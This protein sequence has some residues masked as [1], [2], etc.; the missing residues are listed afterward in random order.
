MGIEAKENVPVRTTEAEGPYDKIVPNTVVSEVSTLLNWDQGRPIV[1]AAFESIPVRQRSLTEQLFPKIAEGINNLPQI[2]D[3]VGDNSLRLAMKSLVPSLSYIPTEQDKSNLWKQIEDDFDGNKPPERHSFQWT[4]E[5]FEGVSGRL[6]DNGI[7]PREYFSEMG[8]DPKAQL[9]VVDAMREAASSVVCSYAF[10]ITRNVKD[11]QVLVDEKT[12]QLAWDALT[13]LKSIHDQIVARIKI[14][15]KIKGSFKKNIPVKAINGKIPPKAALALVIPL[16]LLTSCGSKVVGGVAAP[17]R[18]DKNEALTCKILPDRLKIDVLEGCNTITNIQDV[19]EQLTG[20]KYSDSIEVSRCM[21][22]VSGG[23][24]TQPEGTVTNFARDVELNEFQLNPFK[25]NGEDT[26][27]KPL[28]LA[29]AIDDN[30][31]GSCQTPEGPQA[32]SGNESSQSQTENDICTD[33]NVPL[34]CTAN[35]NKDG[36]F[37][38]MQVK[39]ENSECVVIDAQKAFLADNP[40]TTPDGVMNLNGEELPIYSGETIQGMNEYIIKFGG[41]AAGSFKVEISDSRSLSTNDPEKLATSL[42][43]GYVGECG[44]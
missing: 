7:H 25:V 43:A 2:K 16:V 11:R 31:T 4:G 38:S 26:N 39:P 32:A 17:D 40:D 41:S 21:G 24:G 3:G 36:Q 37:D 8:Y 20:E 13:D 23:T 27:I 15:D 44:D 33:P 9:V 29:I 22:F 6:K 42:Q 34:N 18:C 19:C 35:K 14:S 28:D 12:A 10:E 1:Q 5:L 30:T